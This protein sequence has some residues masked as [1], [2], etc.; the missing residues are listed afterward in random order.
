MGS[1]CLILLCVSRLWLSARAFFCRL[2]N[3]G[4]ACALRGHHYQSTIL[5]ASGAFFMTTPLLSDSNYS[6]PLSLLSEQ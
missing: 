3:G 5:V 1:D 2:L 6:R 4:N